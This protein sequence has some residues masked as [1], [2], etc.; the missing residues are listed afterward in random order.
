MGDSDALPNLISFY[1]S[2]LDQAKRP[3]YGWKVEGDQIK[4][5]FDPANKPSAIKLWSAYN[6]WLGISELMYSVPIGLQRKF[7]YLTQVS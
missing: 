2:I 3:S 5:T 4:V 1:K 7:L 6:P